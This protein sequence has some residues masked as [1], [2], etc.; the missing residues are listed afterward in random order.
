[1]TFN[2]GQDSG[3]VT[4]AGDRVAWRD[5]PTAFFKVVNAVLWFWY[6]AKNPDLPVFVAARVFDLLVVT[7]MI[8]VGRQAHARLDTVATTEPRRVH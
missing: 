4:T 3:R 2:G 1:V 5:V 6:S 8:W 7:V